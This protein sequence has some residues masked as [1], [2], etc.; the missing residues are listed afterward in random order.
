MTFE[1]LEDWMSTP[2]S[3]VNSVVVERKRRL[4]WKLDVVSVETRLAQWRTIKKD[5]DPESLPVG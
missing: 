5:A 2:Q 3:V 4:A 1:Q